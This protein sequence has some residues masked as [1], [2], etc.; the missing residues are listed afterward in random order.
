MINTKIDGLTLFVKNLNYMENNNHLIAKKSEELS[1]TLKQINEGKIPVFKYVENRWKYIN[2]W[3]CCDNK[4][5]NTNNPNGL[6]SKENG[7]I[8]IKSR[9]EIEY[10]NC[11]ENEVKLIFEENEGLS[12]GLINGNNYI[13]LSP[14]YKSIYYSFQNNLKCINLPSFTYKTNDIIGCGLVYPPPNNILFPYIFFTQNGTQ[15]GKAILLKD[16]Y[17]S[18]RPYV[19]LFCCSIE[20]NFGDNSFIYNVSKHCVTEEF[21][22]E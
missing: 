15:I 16:N 4:C 21:Y 11:M 12:I 2:G 1:F 7:F 13:R 19:K 8:Q 22:K 9:T 14:N 3:E 17:E 18:F 20:A 6:C 5:V 10:I